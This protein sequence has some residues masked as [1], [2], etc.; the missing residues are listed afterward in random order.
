MKQW[1]VPTLPL[2]R[3]IL[4]VTLL[5]ALVALLAMG[6]ASAPPRN[7][8]DACAIFAQYP[9]WYREARRAQERWGVPVPVL[10]A[11]IHHESG[12]QA[13]A[14]PPRRRY[15]WIIPGPR[16]S[17]AYGYAQALDGTWDWYRQ[18]TGNRGAD[19]NDFGD[20]VD[21]VGWYLQENRRRNGVALDDAYSQYL[22]YHQGHTG[23][24][25]GDH[26]GQ[27]WLHRIAQGV[28]RQA[29]R[30]AKQLQNCRGELE[31]ERGWG[32]F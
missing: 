13:E 30:Y 2:P 9:H 5:A 12:F 16:R 14:R 3:V 6:C 19:R 18:S 15:L 22:A 27:N 32:L 25:R 4:T 24:A 20:A 29:V 23:Y 11:I 1:P 26:L 31:R 21:F 28:E 10:L 8:N 17:S 7:P